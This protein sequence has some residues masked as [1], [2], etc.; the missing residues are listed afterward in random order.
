[1]SGPWIVYNNARRRLMDG[2]IDLDADAFYM[3]LYMDASNA[4]D[5]TQVVVSE[6]SNEVAQGTGYTTGGQQLAN[7]T[8]DVGAY[9]EEMRFNADTARW[10]AAGG[11]IVGIC[12]AVIWRHGATPADDLL[13]LVADLGSITATN[14]NPFVVGPNVGGIFELN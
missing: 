4:P 13:M 10:D 3:S 9:S 1:M 6:L 8:W 7:V 12:Y 14:G 2:T 5:V 11:D